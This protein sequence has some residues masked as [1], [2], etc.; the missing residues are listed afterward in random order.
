MISDFEK[1]LVVINL[2]KNIEKRKTHIDIIKI[3]A[4]IFVV[5]NHTMAEGF[6]SYQAE[7]TFSFVQIVKCT[8]SSVCKLAVPLFFMCSGILLLGKNESPARLWVKRVLKYI[9]ITIGFTLLYYV[10]ISRINGSPMS[11]NWILN[12]MYS[13]VDF[14]Y[15]GSY[16]FLYSYIA[17]L[18]LLPVFRIIAQNITKQIITYLLVLNAVFGTLIPILDYF[19]GQS[20]AIQ[21][22]LALESMFIYSLCGYYFEKNGA[23]LTT[24]KRFTALLVALTVIGFAI[25][26]F[27]SIKVMPQQKFLGLFGIFI[28]ILILLLSRSIAQGIK[29]KFIKLILKQ[30]SECTFGV[31]ILQGFVFV[32]IN[33]LY[34][35]GTF[36]TAIIRTLIVFG[37]SLIITFVFNTVLL[38]LKTL[39]KKIPIYRKAK[40][41]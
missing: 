6:L 11:L 41:S 31:Y 20:L 34:P 35:I 30:I 36:S 3:I 25:S 29:S 37:V 14:S 7:S 39:F 33:E 8:V 38:L 23:T 5:F 1:G 12:Y 24:N 16:W 19:K 10:Y 18:I 15:S 32:I 40:D 17:F 28:A 22:P 2:Y 13:N 21:I 27:L 4:C 9:L 26:V